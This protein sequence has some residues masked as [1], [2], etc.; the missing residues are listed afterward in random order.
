[1]VGSCLQYVT[2]LVSF[3]TEHRQYDSGDVMF[4]ICLVT[5]RDY[6]FKE[7]CDF[8][9]RSKLP[10]TVSHSLAIFGGH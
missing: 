10:Y 3:V 7:L 2:T 6:M 5:S 4:L 1:M 9:D 8:V